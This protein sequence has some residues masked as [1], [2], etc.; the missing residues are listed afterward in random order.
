MKIPL[1]AAAVR[2]RRNLNFADRIC[3]GFDPRMILCR[4]K[5]IPFFQNEENTAKGCVIYFML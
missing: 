2:I 1:P 3:G 5:N 4:K